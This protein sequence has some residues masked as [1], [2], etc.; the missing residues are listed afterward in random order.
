MKIIYPQQ[1][2]PNLNIQL[3]LDISLV[4]PTEISSLKFQ[5]GITNSS[6]NPAP[7]L[8]FC[9]SVNNIL[10][11]AQFE[12]LSHPELSVSHLPTTPPANP[13]NSTFRTRP[14]TNEFL[15]SPLLTP[16]PKPPCHLA[17]ITEIAFNSVVLD[18]HFGALRELQLLYSCP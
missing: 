16:R 13:L 6:I 15:P 3:F 9:F 5:I 18:F 12:N 11:G 2:S 8:V 7:P 14:E 10:P 4:C 17:S 1:T